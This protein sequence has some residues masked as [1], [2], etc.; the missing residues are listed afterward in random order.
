MWGSGF[1]FSLQGK[2][3]MGGGHWRGWQKAVDGEFLHPDS[4]QV[5][6]VRL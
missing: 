4:P 3:E 6:G 5:F 2:R 1:G